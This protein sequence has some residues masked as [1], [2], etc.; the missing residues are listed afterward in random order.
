VDLPEQVA[1]AS[2]RA[3]SESLTN[4]ARHAQA[5]NVNLRVTTSN[6]LKEMEIEI[7]DDGIGFDLPSVERGHYGLL[8]MRERVRLVGGS[9]DVF[10]EPGRGTQIVIRFPLENPTHD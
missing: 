9:V 5:K 8:G 7:V 2:I 4:I 10:S 1:D 6:D 3:I